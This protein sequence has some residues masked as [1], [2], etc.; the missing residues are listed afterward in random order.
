M[1]RKITLLLL[2][3]ISMNLFSQNKIKGNGIVTSVKTKVNDFKKIIV[4]NDFEVVLVKSNSPAIEI[5]TDEN[6]IEVI[7]FNVSDSI[8]T[9]GTVNKLKPKK[10]L[11]IT[12]FCSENL[13]EIELNNDATIETLNTLNVA[14]MALKVNDYANA[15]IS[16]KSNEFQLI[17]NNQSKIQLRSKTKLNIESPSIDLSIAKSSNTSAIVRTDSLT[18][19]IKEKGSLDIEG[20]TSKQNITT[21]GDAKLKAKNLTSKNT[22]IALKEESDVSVQASE[23]III[24]ASG[25]SKLELYGNPKIEIKQ[26][27]NSAKIYKGEFKKN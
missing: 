14:K 21:K 20:T 19:N 2:F 26:F 9:L 18:I 25:E 1:I 8:F 24:E 6:L 12:I 23:N 17:N 22:F 3:T 4:S 15:D 11:N 5:E 27:L 10:T 13:N 7:K 16:V